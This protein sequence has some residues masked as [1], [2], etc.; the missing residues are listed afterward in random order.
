MGGGK[1]GSDFDP[2]GKSDGEVMRFCQSLMTELCRHI[3]DRHRR[4]RR[5]HRRGRPRDRLHVRPVQAHPQRV[6][7]RA[8]RQGPRVGRLAHPSRGHRLRRGLLRRRDAHDPQRDPRGQD[9]V[10]SRG[11]GNVAQYAIEKI[12]DLRRQAGHLSDSGG[13]IYDEDGIDREKLAFVLDLKNVKRGRIKEY[14]E[15][16]KRRLHAGRPGKDHNPLWDL[17][18]DCAFPCATQNEINAKDAQNLVKNGVYVRLRGRQHADRARGRRPLRREEDPL[19]PRQGRQRRRRRRS[20][21]SSSRRT[22][23]ASAGTV[24][25]STPSC[26]AS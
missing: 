12:I 19:R 15:K 5:R 13:Y 18:A 3:G 7:R 9:R 22:A 16:F 1:G 2:K 6:R 26:T 17:K 20:P 24:K 11:S 21:V 23:C 25:R 14:A 4:P 8:H 10:S